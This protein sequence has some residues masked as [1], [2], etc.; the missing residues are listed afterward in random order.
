MSDKIINSNTIQKCKSRENETLDYCEAR[1]AKQHEKKCQ[2]KA[3]ETIEEQD[4][5]RAYDRK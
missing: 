5:Y 4:A 2:K 3:S 1:L